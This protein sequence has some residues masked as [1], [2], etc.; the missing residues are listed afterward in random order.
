[1]EE[2]NNLLIQ[3][4]YIILFIA[5]MLETLALPIPGGLL[6]GYCGVLAYY[7]K[8]ELLPSIF[9][10]FLGVVTGLTIA[11]IIGSIM[12]IKIFLKYGKYLGINPHKMQKISDFFNIYGTKVLLISC[13]IP[14]IRHITGY[15][16]GII[17][18]KY[19]KFAI[20]S[21][22]GAFIWV[23]TFIFLGYFL[24][25]DFKKIEAYVD[26]YIIIIVITAIVISIFFIIIKYRNYIKQYVYGILKT[27]RDS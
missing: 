1:M 16:C 4:G 15:F 19:K 10:A 17:K 8:L 26:K 23:F 11:Y 2:I 7:G 20:S 24:G 13:F 18:M 12:G 14:G 25:N 3:Y 27:K 21:Y 9:I 6:M 22:I 5:P